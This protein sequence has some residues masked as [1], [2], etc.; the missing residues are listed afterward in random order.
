M[1][2]AGDGYQQEVSTVVEI[3][4]FAIYKFTGAC[5]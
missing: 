4:Q 2:I 1:E 3:I 5:G